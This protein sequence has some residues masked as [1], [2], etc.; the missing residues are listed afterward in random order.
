MALRSLSTL[1]GVNRD[2]VARHLVMAGQLID[3]DPEQAYAHAQAAAKR[4]GRVDV[5]REAAALT[6]YASGRYEEALREVRAVRRMRGDNSLRAVEA[7]AE[8][9]MG[10][11]EKAI[12]II[13]ETETKG[14]ELSEQ[15][16]L[17]L[18]SSGARADLGQNEVGL[19][20]V[21]EALAALPEDTDP[22]LVMRLMSVKADRLREIGRDEEADQVE[23]EMPEVV[24]DP[25]ILDLSLYADAD[26]DK[27]TSPLRG[28]EEAL[29]ATYD[30]ALLDLDGTAYQG[31][32]PIEHAAQATNEAQDAGMLVAYVT[33][34]AMR[35]PAAI[36]EHL[37]ELGFDAAPEAVMTS[38]MDVTA[39]MAEEIEDGSK[40]LVIGAQGL[41]EPIEAAGYT[42]VES[43]DDE[44][45]AVVQGL[46]KSLDWATLSEAAFAIQR[47]AKF[48]ATNL[49]STL[50]VER[51][52]ALGNGALVRAVQHATGVRPT[53]AGK[54]EAGIYHRGAALVGGTNPLAVGDRL[55][56][57]IAGAVTAGIPSLHVLTGV[58]SARDVICAQRGQ[59]PTYLALDM[60][61][62]NESHPRPKHHRDGTWTCGVSQVA[63][64]L[65][66]GTLTVD[67]VAL[68][69][70][71]T[72]TLDTY[73][74]LAA[75]AWEYAMEQR[76]DVT[77]P[78]I[79]VVDN[80][81]PA[82][83][84]V[85]PEEPEVDETMLEAEAE[86]EAEADDAD[87]FGDA[88]ME[89]GAHADGLDDA[90]EETL[91]FLPGEEELEE[92]LGDISD[93]DDIVEDN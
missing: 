1:S 58:S 67:G 56:T 90:P 83:M 39:L 46:D 71:V 88:D 40:V 5:V 22:A 87:G 38:S 27:K 47:G 16:E 73:R 57:D 30:V 31:K 9:G 7:D 69:S 76:A 32:E 70:E 18:V 8:R 53:A 74:A 10:R 14:M 59:R 81:D 25:E 80:D 2:I 61:G 55:N 44:P 26:V 11:P 92:L 49:D 4:A 45:A 89:L 28:T 3:L 17:V 12:Q 15:V 41:R 78:E 79:T 72:V 52:F 6:A 51:G 93:M 33:N 65:R 68:T 54:P 86:A 48:F 20:I 43:A 19:L 77:C 29:C 64:V 63:K 60:R 91:T 85:A 37:R 13:D 62:L 50:P 84:V 42:V 34:N 24:E 35:T 21:D 66:D 75:A 82:G 36:A 23:A